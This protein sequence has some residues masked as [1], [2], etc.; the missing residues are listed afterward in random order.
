MDLKSFYPP[1]C[2]VCGEYPEHLHIY[3]G[4]E[5]VCCPEHSSGHAN[6]SGLTVADAVEAYRQDVMIR[7]NRASLAFKL[8]HRLLSPE[9]LGYAVTS[10]VRDLA[11]KA[12]G[13]PCVETRKV[14]TACDG[15]PSYGGT[16]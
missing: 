12:L 8:C 2:H 11:R 14:R 9:D 16:D 7:G 13:L 5:I 6:G 3:A 4:E 1:P 15:D 10:E